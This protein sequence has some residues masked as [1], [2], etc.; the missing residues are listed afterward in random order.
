[1]TMSIILAFRS[2]AGVAHLEQTVV[3]VE[4]PKIYETN[5]L[6]S[7][8]VG[9]GEIKFLTNQCI[10]PRTESL[11]IATQQLMEPSHTKAQML[12]AFF[13]Q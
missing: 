11:A 2:R 6:G 1:M 7:H 5:M 8:Q 4:P 12:M 9:V 13:S 3:K 10:R